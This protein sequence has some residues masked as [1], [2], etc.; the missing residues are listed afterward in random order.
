MVKIC[1]SSCIHIE[2]VE[3]WGEGE[4]RTGM[5]SRAMRP[6]PIPSKERRATDG[7]RDPPWESS[8]DMKAV[9]RASTGGE[10]SGRTDMVWRRRRELE[11][12]YFLR[13]GQF[14]G[15]GG[16]RVSVG[17]RRHGW[18]WEQ[19]KRRWVIMGWTCWGRSGWECPQR[20]I[21]SPT[22]CPILFLHH[23]C[24]LVREARTMPLDVN[25]GNARSRSRTGRILIERSHALRSH[26]QHLYLVD[27]PSRSVSV[28]QRDSVDCRTL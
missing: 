18:S 23:C 26:S 7:C 28:R 6:R 21:A 14:L 27:S 10:A 20:Y 15:V 17:V 8:H 19:S 12:R 16:R 1:V 22:L 13:G 25:D 5:S 24:L 3:R 11:A 9:S 4:R 2:L